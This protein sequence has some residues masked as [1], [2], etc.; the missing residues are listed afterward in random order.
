LK[1]I[2]S[3]NLEELKQEFLSSLYKRYQAIQVF[4]WL[5]KG[6]TDFDEMTDISKELRGEFK[7]KYTILDAVVEKKFI[8]KI[9]GTIKYLLKLY[10]GE[11]IESVLMKYH[12][13]YSACVSTQVGCKMG[14]KF[15]AT[16]K[17][18]FSRN[19]YPSEMISQIHTAQKDNNIRIS[20]VVLMGI[21]EPLD[22]YDNVLKFLKLISSHQ[23]LNIGMRHISVSTCGVVDK[24]YKLADEGLQITLSISLHETD[25]DRR[26]QIMPI[27][28]KWK[29][30]EI[31][32]ACNY[33]FLKTNRRV[34]FE[35][36]LIKNVNDSN[37]HAK[38]LIKLLKGMNCYINIIPI[39]GIEGGVYE[40]C[41]KEEIINFCNILINGG[42][43]AT[44]RRTL[45]SDINASCGQL[46]AKNTK[47]LEENKIESAQ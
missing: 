24:I 7:S 12:H 19:L 11:F 16:G 46:K 38:N 22:N 32:K 9:D 17:G 15:C 10:D 30:E 47:N 8:S 4:N 42:I 39:N 40:P 21:G 29:I 27:N 1:D 41:S 45:G 18:G 34:S 5:N 31:I 13:G 35:Y 6:I 23:G 28:N 44:I 37:G 3:L 26:S 20:N 36:T 25:D 33:Y 43:T 2:K 14:C